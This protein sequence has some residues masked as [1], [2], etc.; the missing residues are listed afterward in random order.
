[1]AFLFVYNVHFYQVNGKIGERRISLIHMQGIVVLS[2]VLVSLAVIALLTKWDVTQV[3]TLW[4]MIS[5]RVSRDLR[6]DDDED[7][8]QVYCVVEG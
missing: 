6:L 4:S 5:N 2:D 8:V 7:S 1:M 3:M